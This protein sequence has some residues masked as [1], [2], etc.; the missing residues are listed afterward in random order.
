MVSSFKEAW[1]LYT[2]SKP[3]AQGQEKQKPAEGISHTILQYFK[4]IKCR[5][6][7]PG[8]SAVLWKLLILFFA[9]KFNKVLEFLM[10]CG[11]RK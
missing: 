10:N 7:G 3:K 8:H 2:S 1:N 6:T 5:E 9:M 4:P 11:L